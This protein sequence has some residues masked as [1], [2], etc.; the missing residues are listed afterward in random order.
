MNASFVAIFDGSDS[1]KEYLNRNGTLL[2]TAK[3]SPVFQRR[4]RA[5][6][7]GQRQYSLDSHIDLMIAAS[8]A[9]ESKRKSVPSIEEQSLSECH[10]SDK[11]SE[12][13]SEVTHC[14][15]CGQEIL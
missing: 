5:L 9:R 11:S 12:E 13:D 8:V 7:R 3:N 10:E 15:K 14:D 1:L 6:L 4:V 2:V